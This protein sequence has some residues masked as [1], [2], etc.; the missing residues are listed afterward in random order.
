[1]KKELKKIL[2]KHFLLVVVGIFTFVL[3]LTYLISEAIVRTEIPESVKLMEECSKVC[4]NEVESFSMDSTGKPVCICKT[5]FLK[6]IIER[7]IE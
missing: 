7:W 2:V 5:N 3:T 6:K 4:K 1:M